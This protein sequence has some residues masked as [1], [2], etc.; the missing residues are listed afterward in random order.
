[1][2]IEITLTEKH[3]NVFTLLEPDGLTVFQKRKRLH[4]PFGFRSD[5]ASV[6]RFFWRL[7]FPPG[8]PHALRA[9]FAHDFLYRTHPAGWR[10]TE[11]DALFFALLKADGISH[12]CALLAY[13]GVL[14]FGIFSWNKTKGKEK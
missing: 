7:V 1:V 9:A 2:K 11:A 4:V 12:G 10:K 3:G 13:L 14:L 6:P 5:G 8:D